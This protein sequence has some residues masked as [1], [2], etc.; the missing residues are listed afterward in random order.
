MTN[1]NPCDIKKYTCISVAI[2]KLY[3]TNLVYLPTQ[4]KIHL[5]Q[6]ISMICY[7]RKYIT[8][9]SRFYRRHEYITLTKSTGY[10]TQCSIIPANPPASMCTPWFSVG[11]DSYSDSSIICSL[12]PTSSRNFHRANCKPYLLTFSSAIWGAC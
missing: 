4:V 7:N 8:S 11:K 1:S 3:Y 12:K 10:I 6:E 2:T 5:L 9:W